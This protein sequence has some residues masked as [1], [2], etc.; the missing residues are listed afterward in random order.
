MTKSL[1]TLT[2][3]N[4]LLLYLLRHPSP[5]DEKVYPFEV[6]QPGIAR[7]LGIARGYVAVVLQRLEEQKYVKCEPEYVIGV[8]RKMKVAK[9]EQKGRELAVRL[10]AVM[11][12]EVTRRL[13]DKGGE[14]SEGCKEPEEASPQQSD[15]GSVPTSPTTFSF[16]YVIDE[17]GHGGLAEE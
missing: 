14:E 16:T 15:D 2:M 1:G 9:L 13:G 12:E 11:R 3:G 8:K 7:A 10:R 17:D 6:T 4:R 5:K